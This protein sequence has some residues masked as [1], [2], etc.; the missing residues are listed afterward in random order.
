LI[1]PYIY[2]WSFIF[3]RIEATWYLRKFLGPIRFMET[4]SIGFI[5]F[6]SR[7]NRLLTLRGLILYIR[8]ILN[9]IHWGIFSDR[10]LWIPRLWSGLI[11]WSHII[12]ITNGSSLIWERPSVIHSLIF[13]LLW[14]VIAESIMHSIFVRSLAHLGSVPRLWGPFFLWKLILPWLRLLRILWWLCVGS[15]CDANVL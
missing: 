14:V 3:C 13:E 1:N 12:M 5:I 7:Y 4:L 15:H 8:L 2:F 9:L 6:A 11:I 10:A